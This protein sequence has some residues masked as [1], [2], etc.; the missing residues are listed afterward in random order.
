MIKQ[1]LLTS[2]GLWNAG[3]VIL[4]VIAGL[5]IFK[6]GLEVFE[7]DKMNG[8]RDWLADLHF[9]IPVV[10]AYIGKVCELA[11]GYYWLLDYLRG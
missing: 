2:N 1:R 9:P 3:S 7:T 6:F 11:G 8:Y 10:M 5:T 4:R